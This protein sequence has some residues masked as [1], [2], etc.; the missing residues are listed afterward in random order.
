MQPQTLISIAD[1]FQWLFSDDL[2]LSYTT[3]SETSTPSGLQLHWTASQKHIW[4]VWSEH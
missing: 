1:S 4:T 2:P 3:Q